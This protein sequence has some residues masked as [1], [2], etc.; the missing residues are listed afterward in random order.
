MPDLVTVSVAVD[1]RA[2]TRR[3]GK[4]APAK[5]LGPT[6]GTDAGYAACVMGGWTRHQGDLVVMFSNRLAF[7]ALA[8]ACVTA[9]AG[10]AYLATRQNVATEKP[11]AVEAPVAAPVEAASKPVQETEA[12]VAA[13]PATPPT[14]APSPAAERPAPAPAPRR[15]EAP[16]PRAPQAQPVESTSARN[17]QLPT[18]ER[19]WPSTPPQAQAP[20]MVETLPPAQAPPA[21]DHPVSEPARAPEPPQKVFEELVVSADSVIG[22]RVETSVSSETAKVED[23]V[24]ARVV[25]D[26]RSGGS[27]AIPA[28]SR[29]LGTVVTVEHGGKFK[30]QGRLGIRFNTLVLAD[31]TRL[32]ITTETIYQVRGTARPVERG[33]NRRRR[34]CRRDSRRHRRGRQGRGHRRGGGRRC[35]HRDGRDERQQ[36]S[37]PQIRRRSHGTHSLARHDNGREIA[38]I[39]ISFRD[40]TRP[41]L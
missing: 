40:L 7:A 26:V 28:G 1:S 12:L 2:G 34:G 10:G 8:V 11:V 21:D 33:Q 35:R 25:R 5:D 18:L 38:L 29:V 31:G 3:S 24:E 6:V 32:P 19:S 37:D 20:P 23:R 39:S 9:A 15:R 17:S 30:E 22:L 16:R 27:V 41:A 13:A 36:R 4:L 14:A